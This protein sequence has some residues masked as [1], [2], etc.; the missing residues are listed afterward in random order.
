MLNSVITVN[1]SYVAVFLPEAADPSA[2]MAKYLTFS[3]LA[4]LV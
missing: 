3:H 1:V 4:I 2:M